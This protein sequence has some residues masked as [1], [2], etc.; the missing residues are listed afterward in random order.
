[1]ITIVRTER[2][3]SPEYALAVIGLLI[4]AILFTGVTIV[5][6]TGVAVAQGA[7]STFLTL[8][9]EAML[10]ISG[11]LF[12]LS[13]VLAFMV[14]VIDNSRTDPDVRRIANQAQEKL[15][16]QFTRTGEGI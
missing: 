7:T 11:S 5:A 2:S 14:T 10:W 9:Q 3:R 15:E 16:S 1:M 13:I 12:V 8:D 6:S 4:S